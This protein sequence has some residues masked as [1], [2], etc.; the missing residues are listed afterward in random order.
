MNVTHNWSHHKATRIIHLHEVWIKWIYR[1]SFSSKVS[2]PI[3]FISSFINN[4]DLEC[5]LPWKVTVNF[6]IIPLI[7]AKFSSDKDERLI[8][9]ATKVYLKKQSTTTHRPSSVSVSITQDT[10]NAGFELLQ[11]V[12]GGFHK[13]IPHQKLSN[14]CEFQFPLW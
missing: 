7:W 2:L 13:A 12:C 14:R 8:N 10:C 6:V 11:S 3:Y 9:Y 5:L 1:R 4:F